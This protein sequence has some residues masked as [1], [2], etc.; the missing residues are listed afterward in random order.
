MSLPSPH[1]LTLVH[2]SPHFFQAEQEPAGLCAGRHAW[3]GQQQLRLGP[4]EQRPGQR[5][6]AGAYERGSQGR[7]TGGP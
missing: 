2:T 4:V 1:I 5:G 6:P 3:D 7:P